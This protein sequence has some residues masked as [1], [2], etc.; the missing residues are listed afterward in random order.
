MP[1]ANKRWNLVIITADDL[2]GD[3][4]GWMGSKVGATPHLDAFAATC[5]QFRNCHVVTPLCQPSRSALMT[6]RLP[7]RNGALSFEP[8]RADVTTLTELMSRH[9]Y[10]TA[11]IN[12]I[13]H[14][15]PRQKFDWDIALEGSGK[16]PKTL[17]EQFEQCIAVA[18]EKGRPFF[19]N[20]NSTDP[21]RP[22]P[23]SGSVTEKDRDSSAPPRIFNESEIFVPAFLEN[24]PA[25]REEMAQYF[26][27]VARLDES[28]GELVAALTAAGELD[29]TIIVFLSDHGMSMPYSK[30]SLYRNATW[31]PVLLWFPGTERPI[32]NTEM[33]SSVDIMPTILD[34]LGLEKPD[35]FD[36]N[37]WL[38]L[39]QG[40]NEQGRDYVFTQLNALKSG[41]SFPSRCVRS[42]TRA[43]IWN[44]WADGRRRFGSGTIGNRGSWQAMIEAGARDPELKSRVGHFVYRRP[45]EF[46]DEE[47]DPDERRNLI[48]DPNRQT[49]IA[50]MKTL[51][52]AHMEKTDDPLTAEFRSGQKATPNGFFSRWRARR[53]R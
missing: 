36:G 28:F 43:Y 7:H 32:A 15:M 46:Y 29:N 47:E 50:Q 14:M 26:S 6:G 2:N 18:A 23:G 30:S 33:V 31:S 34:L 16:N 24:L 19:I 35:G 13:Q 52:L 25:V 48:D 39:L 44:P 27:A 1:A 51:L 3:S 37:S 11:A 9:G 40:A 22:F 41:K 38:P 42:R 17:R 20:A 4:T 49:E 45:E 12:K 8:I 5:H 10:F 21:H 53:G